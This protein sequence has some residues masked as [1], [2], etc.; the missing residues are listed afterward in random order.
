[1]K[2]QKKEKEV[3]INDFTVFKGKLSVERAK[4]AYERIKTFLPDYHYGENVRLVDLNLFLLKKYKAEMVGFKDIDK[5][6][7]TKVKRYNKYCNDVFCVSEGHVVNKEYICS[8]IIKREYC[9]N[10][11]E[12][13]DDFFHDLF[14]IAGSEDGKRLT[15]YYIGGYSEGFAE[16]MYLL[17]G[18]N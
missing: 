11:S 12:N 15:S 18:N 4:Q 5:C 7:R 2:D 10:V 16:E 17:C 8:Y 6:T 3:D 13:K 1:M 9:N 14:V